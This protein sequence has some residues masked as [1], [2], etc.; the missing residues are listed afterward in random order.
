[1]SFF[2]L[3]YFPELGDIDVPL[4]VQISSTPPHFQFYFLTI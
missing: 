2:I 1:M 4:C 3:W